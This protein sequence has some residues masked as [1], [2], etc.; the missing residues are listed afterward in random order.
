[1]DRRVTPPKRVTSPTC[2]PPPPC[3]Q[4]LTRRLCRTFYEKLRFNLHDL[5]QILR[6]AHRQLERCPSDSFIP[7]FPWKRQPIFT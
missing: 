1:M 4:A 5:C 6:I 2:S 3:K 7:L